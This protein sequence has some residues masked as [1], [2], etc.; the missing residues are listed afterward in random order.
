[1]RHS[2]NTS[3]NALKVNAFAQQVISNL[4]IT[5]QQFNELQTQIQALQTTQET[6][7]VSFI[8]LITPFSSPVSVMTAPPVYASLNPQAMVIIAQIVT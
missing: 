2:E 3:E 8:L 1:M 5:L 4:T 6:F 7:N